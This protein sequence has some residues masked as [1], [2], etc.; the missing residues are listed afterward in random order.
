MRLFCTTVGSSELLV[1]DDRD[2]TKITTIIILTRSFP[3]INSVKFIVLNVN[4]TCGPIG[5]LVFQYPVSLP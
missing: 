3:N 2:I 1:Q 5:R 4:R